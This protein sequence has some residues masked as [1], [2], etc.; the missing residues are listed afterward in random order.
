MFPFV[1]WKRLENKIW[2]IFWIHNV[3]D[4]CYSS[5]IL[6]LKWC[7]L[8][9]ILDVSCFSHITLIFYYIELWHVMFILWRTLRKRYISL[10]LSE[11]YPE[12]CSRDAS[13]KTWPVLNLFLE[14]FT[15][16]LNK[17]RNEGAQKWWRHV[18]HKGTLATK[19][20][21]RVRAEKSG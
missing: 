20:Q 2:N 11:K 19:E 1:Y 16:T 10:F 15:I 14:Q 13:D 6:I 21:R 9:S 7:F 8:Y 18:R 5:R 12:T 17:A 4:I 3:F